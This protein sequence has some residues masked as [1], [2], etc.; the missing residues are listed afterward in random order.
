MAKLVCGIPSKH[1]CRVCLETRP[2]S[3]S[4]PFQFYFLYSDTRWEQGLNKSLTPKSLF[5]GL[6]IRSPP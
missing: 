5:P 4:S 6:L 3:A 1:L 2:Y